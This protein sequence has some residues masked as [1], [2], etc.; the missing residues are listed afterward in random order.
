MPHP[1]TGPAA[2]QIECMET[3]KAIHDLM[4]IATLRRLESR[5]KFSTSCFCWVLTALQAM[6]DLCCLIFESRRRRRN[7]C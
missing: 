2:S 6:A 1:A 4:D 7:P 3:V 5:P